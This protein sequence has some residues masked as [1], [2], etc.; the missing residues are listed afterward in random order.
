MDQEKFDAL[1]HYICARCEDP[2]SLGATKLNKI[3]W[4]SDEAPI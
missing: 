3:M 4:Y 2:T 1:V